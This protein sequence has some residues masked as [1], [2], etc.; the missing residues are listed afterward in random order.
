MYAKAQETIETVADNKARQFSR[1]AWLESDDVKQEVRIKCYKILHTYEPKKGDL[2]A[3]LAKCAEY[4]LRD[5]RRSLQYKHN[6]PCVRCPLWDAKAAKEGKHDCTEFKNKM[7]C[8]KFARHE[9]YVQVK[10]SASH[11]VNINDNVLHDES[12]ER[13][14]KHRDLLEYVYNYLPKSLLPSFRSFLNSNFNLRSLKS[15]ERIKLIEALV[16]IL[17]IYYEEIY[18]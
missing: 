6:P 16:D 1:V 7:D 4:R 17:E 9:R 15:K 18:D 11:P 12:F 8:D 5:I 13:R 3:Y 14:V 2:Q 10:L